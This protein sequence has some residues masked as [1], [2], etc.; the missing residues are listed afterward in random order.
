ML[1]GR[2]LS[3]GYVTLE[4]IEVDKQSVMDRL[5]FAKIRLTDLEALARNGEDLGGADPKKRQQFIQE[6]FFHLLGA[7][8][9][10]AQVVNTSKSL[11]IDIEEVTI[12]RVCNTLKNDPIKTILEELH[13]STR[14][15]SLPP[16]PYPYSDEGCHFRIV[17]YRNRVCHHGD[18]PFCFRVGSSP[19]TSLFLDPRDTNRRASNE[20]AIRELNHFYDLVNAKCQQVLAML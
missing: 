4:T 13:P 18:N 14:N 2:P 19:S 3:T 11:G 10:L 1:K 17:V 7:T 20:S 6:F 8:E 15:Q 5:D 12:N 9:F 16:D